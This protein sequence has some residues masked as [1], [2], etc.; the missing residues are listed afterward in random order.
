MQSEELIRSVS[1]AMQVLRA[2]QLQGKASLAEVQ[3]ETDLPKPTL[4]RLLHTL[5]NERAV[6]RAEG[7]GLWRPAFEFVPTR[8]LPPY[9]QKLIKSAMPALEALRALVVWPSDLAVRDGNCMRLL[10]TTRRNSGLAVNRD[11]IGHTIDMLR[12]A[13]G[14]AYI[15]YCPA[16]ERESLASQLAAQDG[17]NAESVADE[18]ESIRRVVLK[19]GYAVRDPSFGGHAEAIE[20]FD[21][22]L[23]AI[24][25]PVRSDEEVLACINIVWLKRFDARSG[26]A[27]RHL[28]HLRSAAS[29]IAVSWDDLNVSAYGPT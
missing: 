9:H 19:N 17:S 22:K 3:R 23:S 11:E 15:A 20:R 24:A 7:D 28:G 13:V 2:L 14:R 12:S 18:M 29:A 8:I 5:E 25:V 27:S 1:R 26:I 4:L 6:W 16:P 10:E 21:D